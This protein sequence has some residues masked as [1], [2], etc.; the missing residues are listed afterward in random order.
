MK[1]LSKI[2]VILMIAI[3][4]I[5]YMPIVVN[6]AGGPIDAISDIEADTDQATAASQDLKTM[7]GKFLGLV[8]I[9]SAIL[10]VVLIAWFGFNYI[11]KSPSEKPKYMDNFIPLIAGII[12]T[13]MAISIAKLIFSILQ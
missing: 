2:L 3:M 13:F 1:K 5:S 4:A 9:A 8:Q 11:L 10:A 12:L 7:I 6:A